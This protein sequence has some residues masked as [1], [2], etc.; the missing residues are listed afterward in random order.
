[1]NAF[2]KCCFV[3]SFFSTEETT[4]IVNPSAAGTSSTGFPS[5]LARSLRSCPITLRRRSSKK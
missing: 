5:C 4:R 2:M 3:S 1:M